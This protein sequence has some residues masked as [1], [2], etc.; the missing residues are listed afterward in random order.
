MSIKNND[1]LWCIC[2]SL[3]AEASG[4]TEPSLP[5]CG[6]LHIPSTPDKYVLYKFDEHGK[7]T[8]YMGGQAVCQKEDLFLTLEDAN[9]AYAAAM[10]EFLGKQLLEVNKLTGK[11][12]AWLASLSEEQQKIINQAE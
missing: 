11:F 8:D 2:P 7:T 10:K 9:I 1:I 6:K 5:W 3:L 4:Q 12:N